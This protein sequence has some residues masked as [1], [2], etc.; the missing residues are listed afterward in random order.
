MRLFCLAI[1]VVFGWSDGSVPTAEIHVATFC[2]SETT[3]RHTDTVPQSP[4]D[5]LYN[6]QYHYDGP[7]VLGVGPLRIEFYDRK[8]G[9]WE[10]L[11]TCLAKMTI[12]SAGRH[13]IPTFVHT[14]TSSYRFKKPAPSLEQCMYGTIWARW[15][16][17]LDDNGDLPEYAYP[18]D[19][20]WVLVPLYQVRDAFTRF[21]TRRPDEENLLLPPGMRVED[22]GR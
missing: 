10:S 14:L 19:T 15:K 2:H 1:L 4:G 21:R 11:G 12:R 5:W 7:E 6:W 20:G 13:R 17:M 22:N 8:P 3:Y 16:P 18:E 9:R